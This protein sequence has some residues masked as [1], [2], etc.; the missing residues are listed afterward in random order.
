MRDIGLK[1]ARHPAL[2]SAF[3]Q[4]FSEIQHGCGIV[5]RLP[6]PGRKPALPIYRADEARRR[7]AAE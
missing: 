3:A 4:V 5:R 2:D 1:H 7:A 6:V